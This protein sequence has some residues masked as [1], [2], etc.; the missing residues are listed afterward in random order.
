MLKRWIPSTRP[1]VAAVLC[2]VVA[3][4]S[5]GGG[6]TPTSPTAQPSTGGA[7]P[8]TTASDGTT[9]LQNLPI[10]LSALDYA[11]IVALRAGREPDWLPL[12]DFGRV[13]PVTSARPVSQ[14]NPQPTFFAPL[15]TPVLAVVS[16]TVMSVSTLYSNDFSIMIASPG[17]GGTWEHE[18]VMNVRVTVGARVTAG[19]QIGE[20]SDYEC[21]WGR[22]GNP[23]DPL[24]QSRLG[25]VEIGL[26]YGGNPPMH[27]CPFEPEVVAPERQAD[28]FGQLTS[29]RSR[30]KAAF[31]DPDLFGESA[32]AT[33]HCVTLGRVAG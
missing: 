5:G 30:I 33:P 23:S 10:D 17:Q 13:L 20:V 26:L 15:G 28:I 16:G 24:C 32:W 8:P 7:A 25:L 21:S 6:A 27:R 3:G 14:P 1:L 2:C 12:E 4:C 29:A 31:G 11:A 9:L 18:H 19:Q 22:G